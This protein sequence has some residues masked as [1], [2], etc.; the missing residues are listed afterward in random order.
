[1]AEVINMRNNNPADNGRQRSR[2][3]RRLW[4]EYQNRCA[5]LQQLNQCLDP[6][7]GIRSRRPGFFSR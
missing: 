7:Q 6:H 2:D 4:L 3:E 1:M 5:G